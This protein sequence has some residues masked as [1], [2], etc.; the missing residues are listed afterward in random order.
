MKRLALFS[1]I[2]LTFVLAIAS[3]RWSYSWFSDS[4][5][6]TNNVFAATAEFASPTPT[7]IPIA[8][9]LVI[10][11]VLPVT[12]CK[13][14][15]TTAQWLEI[16]NG[17]EASVNLKN[18][19]LTDGSGNTI[20]LVT[21][22]TNVPPG[23]LALISHDNSIWGTTQNKCYNPQGAITANFGGQLNINTGHL[24]LL[25]GSGNPIDTVK[26]GGDTGLSPLTDQSIEREPKGHDTDTTNGTLFTPSDFEVRLTPMPGV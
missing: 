22:V 23:G 1:T 6:S 17:Y 12:T 11:E 21:A 8:Q 16:Y 9:V 10:N 19:K 4:A 24:V 25:D 15:N 7:P 5:Q 18:F 20:D 13:T 26:W 2:I 14:G 3:F